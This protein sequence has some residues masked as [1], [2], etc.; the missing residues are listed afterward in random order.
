MP[1][2]RATKVI[3]PDLGEEQLAKLNSAIAVGA[4]IDSGGNSPED[5]PTGIDMAELDHRGY[6]VVY[7]RRTREPSVI[8][9]DAL[10]KQLKKIDRVEDGGTGGLA[11]TLDKPKQPPYRGI[12][13]CYLHAD[14]PDRPK[15]DSYG[16]ITCRKNNLPTEFQRRMH[17]T[18]KHK[19]EW[20]AIQ[21]ERSERDA[22]ERREYERQLIAA[23][24]RGVPVN[25]AAAALS[26]PVES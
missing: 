5:W 10:S 7:H 15:W 19:Q 12:L 17:M 3:Q 20:A 16:F 6:V 24:Q 18:R 4:E 11:F 21:A 8:L 25:V 13:K 1:A 26:A 9:V 22:A 2:K 14:D 23:V